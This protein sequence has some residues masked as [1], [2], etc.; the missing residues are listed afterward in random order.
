MDIGPFF[1]ATGAQMKTLA[2]TTRETFLAKCVA[3]EDIECGDIVAVLDEIAEFASFMWMCDPHVLP[4]HEL[5]R[6]MYRSSDNGRPLKVK[7][8]CLPFVFVKPPRGKHQ[9]LDVRQ[10]RLVRLN[11]IYGKKVWKKL[12]RQK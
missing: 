11:P 10:C 5:V 4:P 9:T 7:A 2:S 3:A 8:I 1:I 12:K 6:V